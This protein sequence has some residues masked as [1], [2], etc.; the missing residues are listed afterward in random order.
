MDIQS[1]DFLLMQ[2]APQE[3]EG[4]QENV[5]IGASSGRKQKGTVRVTEGV[6]PQV[7]SI[8]GVFGRRIT[9]NPE[10]RGKGVHFN[11]LIEYIFERMDTVS[12]ALEACIKVKVTRA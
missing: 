8:P 9:G 11:T 1:L 5:W 7:V 3:S 2:I 12:A 10:P 4:I 6:H